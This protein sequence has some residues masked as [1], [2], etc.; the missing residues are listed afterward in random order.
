[1]LAVFACLLPGAVEAALG[2]A[3]I[4]VD[5]DAPND[6][7]PGDPT[8]SD[9]AE[10]GS[11]E[12]PFDAIQEG[13]DA[14]QPGDEVVLAD[15]LYTGTGNKNLKFGGKDL[16]VRSA[17]GDPTTC[18][19]DCE[20]DGR[21][22]YFYS[23]ETQDSVVAGLTIQNGDVTF[24]SPGLLSYGGGMHCRNS[25]P[26]IANNIITGNN[27]KCGGGLYL[28]G[29]SAMIANNIITGNS[30]SFGGGLYLDESSPTMTNNTITGNSALVAGGL[31]L[32]LSSPTM[33]NNTI[34]G[35]SAE[36][37]AGGL[38]LLHSSPTMANN[39]IMGNSAAGGD[40][41][42][43]NLSSSHPTMINNTI[44]DNSAADDAGGL[45]LSYSS[46]TMVNNDITGNSASDEGGGLYLWSSVAKIANNTITGN[47]ASDGGGL[48]LYSCS[49]TM[50]NNTITGNIAS[51]DGGGVCCIGANSTIA[52]TTITGNSASRGGG[53]Y[54]QSSS[55]TTTNT[56]VAFNSSGIYRN[57]GERMLRYNC[58]YDNTEYDYSGLPDLTGTDGN[59]SADPL[60][61][62]DPSDGGDGWGDDPETPGVDEG[63]N[64]D[65]GDQRLLPGSPCID[66]GD[67]QAVPADTVD[68]DADGDTGERTPF[69]LDGGPRFVDAPPSGGSGLPDPP[70][71]PQIV[72][73]GAHEFADCNGNNTDDAVDIA[74]GAV[75]DIDTD[76]IPDECQPSNNRCAY[77]TKLC[78]QTV[79]AGTTHFASSYAT[80]ACDGLMPKNEVWYS[81]IGT[82]RSTAI[83]TA[84]SPMDTVVA[85][86]V[87]RCDSLACIGSDDDGGGGG[88]L[89]S[90]VKLSTLPLVKY[91]VAVWEKSGGGGDF[92]VRMTC[93]SPCD[94]PAGRCCY[95]PWPNC[96]D[97]LTKEECV[98]TYAGNW[99]EGLDCTTDCPPQAGDSPPLIPH[100]VMPQ[101][102]GSQATIKNLPGSGG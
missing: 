87:G 37:G 100:Q 65:F 27:A 7:G 58:V 69:D 62:R 64:D 49:P 20:G 70:D 2:Q 82:G 33:V 18:I 63:A 71:Y 22:F 31:Y 97:D 23:G 51:N 42:G 9:S 5:D 59:I 10:D 93:G 77:A 88:D 66:A 102:V 60:F 26:T 21:G 35:N 72:D 85:V 52:N 17:S 47:S 83:D 84:G 96:A 14:A 39:T 75:E 12:H 40:G 48:Y 34:A 94:P 80:T 92:V 101:P 43:L 11:A 16:T 1:M 6:P 24:N 38:Q 99:D 81:F 50:T 36:R 53:L 55:A 19:I 67:S 41:G 90:L 61:V 8:V 91:Y 32:Y 13:I 29:S 76:G 98:T 86:Y 30:P 3:V 4:H 74:G 56:I 25:S 89:T 45:L 78:C 44:K 73:M 57:R 15:G 68:L 54:L 79:L 46:P 95:D 28:D